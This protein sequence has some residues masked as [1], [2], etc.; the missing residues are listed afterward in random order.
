MKKKGKR[1][2]VVLRVPIL[3]QIKNA[4]PECRRG[5]WTSTWWCPEVLLRTREKVSLRRINL[6]CNTYV[7]GSNARNLP[8]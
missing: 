6:G 4:S 2:F 3:L 8:V 5:C 7:H 1:N